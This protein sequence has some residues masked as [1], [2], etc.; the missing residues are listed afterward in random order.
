M[1]VYSEKN[2][3]LI[4]QFPF[5]TDILSEKMEPNDESGGSATNNLTIRVQKADGD[6]M[7]RRAENFG[8]GDGSLVIKTSGAR[9]GQI[10]RQGEYLFAIGGSQNKIINRLK[11]IKTTG[12]REDVY[13]GS[14]LT[15]TQVTI[16]AGNVCHSICHITKYLV[17]V[18]VIA[19]HER[20]IDSDYSSFGKMIDRFVHLTIYKQPNEGF[21]ELLHSADIFTN[22][23]LDGHTLGRGLIKQDRDFIIMSGM[24]NEMC[25]TFQ[26]GAYLAG[27]KEWLDYEIPWTS[28]DITVTCSQPYEYRII[29]LKDSFCAV[30][31]IQY[32]SKSAYVY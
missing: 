26:D 19:W 18:T 16:N 22:L 25:F 7:F 5:V 9:K 2:Q 30:S 17:W 28:G 23:S 3:K 1:N 13:G 12:K 21:Y 4:K 15:P 14:I 10:M 29:R 11:W 24:L 8:L 6:L 27:M 32:G 20:N 31:F